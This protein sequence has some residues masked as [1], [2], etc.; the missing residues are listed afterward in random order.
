[1]TNGLFSLP[2]GS[3]AYSLFCEAIE[4]NSMRDHILTGV[5]VGLSGGADSVMLTRLLAEYRKRE[6][7]DFKI[8]AVHVNH[9]IR[10][11]EADRDEA[12]ARRFAESQG[13]EFISRRVDVPALVRESGKSI[14]EAA[15]DAR[16]S[17]FAD[18]ISS[19][20]DV[21]AIALG[22][23][24]TDNLETVIF[25]MMRGAGTRGISGIP[26]VRDNIIRPMLYI[27]KT[28]ITAALDEAGI[29][30]VTDS[31]NFDTAYTRNYIRHE[32][33]P[34]LSKLTDSPE[35]SVRR[36]TQNIRVDGE[37]ID[38]VAESFLSDCGYEPSPSALVIL[39]PAVRYRAISFMASRVSGKS[40][41][42]VHVE[43]ISA[44]LSTGS[45]SFDLPG[46]CSFVSSCGVCRVIS[47]ETVE[48]DI[49]VGVGVNPVPDYAAELVISD[50][51]SEI[52]HNVYKFSI[53]ADLSS[54]IIVGGLRL[55][56]RRAGD[57][58]RYGGMTHKLKKMLIDAKIPRDLRDRVPVLADDNGVVWVPGFG[59]RDDGGGERLYASLYYGDGGFYVRNTQ[60]QIKKKGADT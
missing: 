54:A 12:F 1:M 3:M 37:Y 32:I 45:F 47:P 30:Y 33:I 51:R 35:V 16:Y 49:P 19:R 55:R 21:S 24:A 6:G 52:S 60:R 42:R 29:D 53:Q 8:L 46:G 28:D 44:L 27:A 41:E 43:R 25:N 5:L 10:G 58:Y 17:V 38:G 15:R 59:V 13:V 31:T 26:P 7:I 57:E 14:E 11:E 9:G 23:N 34:A 56:Q 2:M 36:L 50:S 18:I 39:H 48:F 20:S 4:D 40:P 22:H